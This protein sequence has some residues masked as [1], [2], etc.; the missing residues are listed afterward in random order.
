MIIEYFKSRCDFVL[1]P[2]SKKLAT[3]FDF[4]WCDYHYQHNFK[5]LKEGKQIINH[6]ENLKDLIS[7]KDK[8]VL[9]YRDFDKLKLYDFDSTDFHFDTYIFDLKSKEYNEEEKHFFNNV[10]DGLW[11][12]KDPDGSLG[13]GIQLF[14]NVSEIK[15]RIKYI[16]EH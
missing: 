12:T 11:I 14:K 1:M 2:D 4:K 16:K 3:D 7:Y 15:E 10:N 13:L 5:A 6:V 9:T 8:I